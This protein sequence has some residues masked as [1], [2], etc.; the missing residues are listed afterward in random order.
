VTKDRIIMS[1]ALGELVA[2][3]LGLEIM[4]IRRIIIDMTAM[5]PLAIYVEMA[6]TEKLLDLDWEAALK[7]AEVVKV[8]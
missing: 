8:E 1:D 5:E 2:K 4:K 7:G 6:G 3:A